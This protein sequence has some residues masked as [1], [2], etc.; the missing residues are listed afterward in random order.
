[1]KIPKTFIGIDYGKKDSGNTVIC[2]KDGEHMGFV[3][4]SKNHDPDPV[5]IQEAEK[6]KAEYIFLDA[7]L[8]LPKVYFNPSDKEQD[9]FYRKCDR[10][11]NAMSPMFIG[12][13]TAR[14]I[15][16]RR[17][18]EDR[19]FIVKE[20][21]PSALANLLKLQK[22]GYKEKTINIIRCLDVINEQFH[23]YNLREKEM[24][25]W[26]HFDA[27]LALISGGRYL[28]GV[29]VH[30]GNSGEGLIYV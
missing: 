25:T 12:G 10:D 21:Y 18:L 30:Y 29:A 4:T 17:K 13:L 28:Q 24:P 1:M 14:A 11:L 22:H 7:P 26:H 5:I 8:S 19:G 6:M 20:V 15:R 3:G 23:I 9:Y 16:L 2:Y 27:L